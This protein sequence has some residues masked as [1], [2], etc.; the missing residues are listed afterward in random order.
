M[1]TREALGCSSAGIE[2][3]LCMVGPNK[4][5][6]D[7]SSSASV[8]ARFSEQQSILT[9]ANKPKVNRSLLPNRDRFA[10]G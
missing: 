2:D 6:K 3:P 8:V 7:G 1:S 10:F 9:A 4:T 5:V